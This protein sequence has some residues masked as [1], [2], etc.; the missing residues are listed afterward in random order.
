[1]SSPQ[2]YGKVVVGLRE[3]ILGVVHHVGMHAELAD[4]KRFAG[5]E[6]RLVDGAAGLTDSTVDLDASVPA[7]PMRRMRHC[8]FR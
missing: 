6:D 4:S 3:A 2:G 1:M 5:L 8:P 7:M